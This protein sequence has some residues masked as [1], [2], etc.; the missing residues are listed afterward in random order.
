MPHLNSVASRL[1]A[2][3]DLRLWLAASAAL[4]ALAAAAALQPF[5]AV[6]AAPPDD[7]SLEL[8]LV[9]DSDNVVPVGSRVTVR[10]TLK[11]TGIARGS[12]PLPITASSLFV[13]GDQ[14]WETL[15][16]NRLSVND[17]GLVGG[18]FGPYFSAPDGGKFVA[19]DGRTMVI[20]GTGI[21]IVDLENPKGTIHTV[22]TVPG[23]RI[24]STR[25]QTTGGFT[26]TVGSSAPSGATAIPYGTDG[27]DI[28]GGTTGTRYWSAAGNS[29]EPDARGFGRSVAVWH[30]TDDLAWVFVGSKFDTVNGHPNIGR[31]YIYKVD[32][33]G[34][35]ARVTLERNIEP[36]PQDYMNHYAVAN[37]TTGK[38][39]AQFGSSVAISAN[40]KFLAVAAAEMNLIGAVYVYERPGLRTPTHGPGSSDPTLWQDWG[41]LTQNSASKLSQVPIPDWDRDGDIFQTKPGGYDFANPPD[42]TP[43][44]A[45]KYWQHWGSD[46][47]CDAACKRVWSYAYTDFGK[48]AL[49]I[50]E[51]GLTIVVGA[52]QKALPDFFT[53]GRSGYYWPPCRTAPCTVANFGADWVWEGNFR[54]GEAY[55]FTPNAQGLAA[56]YWRTNRWMLGSPTGVELRRTLQAQPF[57]EGPGVQ[58]FGA[59]IDVSNDGRSVAV[60]APGAAPP[61]ADPS[62]DYY[63]KKTPTREGKVYVFNRPAGG[64]GSGLDNSPDATFQLAADID[65][66]NFGAHNVD[67]SPD[68]RRLA[69]SDS[70]GLG[71]GRTWIF[72]GTSGAWRSATTSSATGLYSPLAYGGAG[73]GW[74]TYELG[75]GDANADN[76]LMVG[77]GRQHLWVYDRHLNLLP[78]DPDNGGPCRFDPVD[79]EVFN[80]DDMVSCE[81]ALPDAT[82]EIP[83][84]TPDGTFTISGN[85]TVDGQTVTDQLEVRISTIDEVASVEFGLD[86]QADGSAY[87]SSVARTGVT[88]T[89]MLLKI[90]NENGA[91]SAR[92]SISSVLFTTTQGRLSV[93]LAGSSGACRV[94]GGLTCQ[95]RS[96]STALS[97]SNADQ[98]RL[99]LTHPGGDQTGTATVRVSVLTTNGESYTPEPI[100]VTFAGM[101]T[102]LAIAKPSVSL[103]NFNTCDSASDEGCVSVDNRDLLT[104]AVTATDR[105]GNPT[106]VP[107]SYGMARI[108]DPDGRRVASDKIAVT[109]PL[110]RDGDDDGDEITSADPLVTRNGAPQAQLNVNAEE[111]AKLASGVYTL[112]LRAGSLRTT[113]TF[114]LSGGP[115]A[116]DLAPPERAPQVNSQLTLTATVT[117]EDGNA[118]PDGTPVRW[119]DRP[120]GTTT[121]LVQLSVQVATKDG[122]ASGNYLV[123]APGSAYVTA[124]S[125]TVTDIELLR[126][127][128]ATART[129][130]ADSLS[131]TKPGD[132]STWLS[133]TRVS[134]SVL[135]P[136]LERVSAILLWDGVNEIWL[137]YGQTADGRVI[138]GSTDYIIELGAVLWLSE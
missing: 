127:S 39:A 21:A 17:Q 4:L 132:F 52:E 71:G 30:E 85:V 1:T 128:A 118:V 115:A 106:A 61:G 33:S 64:W 57:G 46:S 43:D 7:I 105:G 56:G 97:A 73:Y 24:Y 86:T 22:V 34:N 117:D 83:E 3:R 109:W 19:M 66:Q 125:G 78:G 70:A 31:L 50:S 116:I 80:G 59:R 55:V 26:P 108:T 16:R 111:T 47:E 81:L 130:L 51:D 124:E 77:R 32:Y 135:L 103:L 75:G 9:D 23:N 65:S 42:G 92:G 126:A 137:R 99:T 10:A 101:A 5:G 90:L 91:A 138:P 28:A 60:T 35:R 2:L 63:E 11:Y 112:E 119:T 136:T 68:S 79:G 62:I 107:S 104:L 123:V 13:S 45:T 6:H 25:D 131:S 72:S 98:I 94:T 44:G 102:E 15:G 69:I 129:S 18:A 89:Q 67:F 53:T 29:N 95:L 87:P 8:S 76:R 134:A 110:R 37:S 41:D 12:N 20:G 122:K 120:I 133:R 49:A 114:R 82:I 40:G 27:A 93:S 113:Q 96:P 121:V 74:A 58:N 36:Q 14:E 38:A 84:G 100:A 88:S 54:N 48:D